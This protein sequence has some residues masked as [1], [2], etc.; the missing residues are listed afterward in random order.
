MH[1]Q[2]SEQIIAHWHEEGTY[3]SRLWAALA[4]EQVEHE[5]YPPIYQ[6]EQEEDVA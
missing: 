5:P 3:L 2:T 6:H 1:K 4:P